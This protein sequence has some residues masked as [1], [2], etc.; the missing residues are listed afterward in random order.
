MKYKMGIKQSSILHY[1]S[2]VCFSYIKSCQRWNFG[3]LTLS[4]ETLFQAI[5][6]KDRQNFVCIYIKT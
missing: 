5:Y 1:S 6:T 4:I 3:E 2:L